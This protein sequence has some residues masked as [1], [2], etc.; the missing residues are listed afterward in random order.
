ME[1]NGRS[2]QSGR[3]S[4]GAVPAEDHV[5]EHSRCRMWRRL[6]CYSER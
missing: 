4:S 5:V 2:N 1:R 6:K 3:G